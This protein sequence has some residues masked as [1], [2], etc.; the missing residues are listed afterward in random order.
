MKLDIFLIDEKSSIKEALAKIDVNSHGIIF[1]QKRSGEIIGVATDGDIRR[2]LIAGLDLDSQL[3]EC[4]NK[5]FYWE[6]ES[7]SRETLIKKLDHNIRAIPLLDDSMKLVDIIT[8][9]NLPEIEERPVYARSKSPV[10]ISFGGGGSDLTH[11]FSDGIG[12]VI[13]A[14]ISF[15]SHATLHIRDDSK[16]IINSLDLNATLKADNLEG[17][18]KAPG[19]FGLIQAVIKTVNPERGFELD[20]HS[21][22]PMS[23]GLGGSAVVAAAILGCFNEFR[24][25]EWSLHELSELAY[26]AERLHQG[27][28]GGWQDQYATI[29]GGFNFIEFQ[30]DQNIVYPLRIP[31][32]NLSELEESLVLCN[33]GIK[34]DSG[35]IHKDQRNQMKQ[36]DVQAVV[37]KNV[38]LCY[39]IRN[40]L[41][42]GSLLEFGTS[43]NDAWQ[44]KRR[45]SNAI[46][47]TH[48]DDIYTNAMSNGA[49]GG[50]LLGAGGGG[51]FLFFVPPSKKHDLLSHLTSAGLEVKPFRFESEGL[52]SWKVR[53]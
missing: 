24:K 39:K 6:H 32:D 43:L 27:I 51:F 38:E 21:D 1:S 15:Y 10:R 48:L 9:D 30:M 49:I 14:T 19:D 7:V 13:N 40:Q 23:S 5:D 16:I 12:A 25:D 8:K 33:T 35:N 17:L 34:H 41:L 2:S 42:R 3:I 45:L 46:S 20:L 22:F 28:E 52:K 18:L 29:F 47:N 53:L 37:Q 26:Q 44:L 11:F 36:K 50:K 31:L 4:I